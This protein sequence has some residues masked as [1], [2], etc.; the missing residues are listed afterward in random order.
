MVMKKEK[1]IEAILVISTGFL[2]FFLFYEKMWMLYVAFGVG[3]AGIFIKPL[4]SLI[5]RGW[6]KLG[7]LL[8]FVVSNVVLVL[9]FYI[10][11]VPI[12]LLYRLFNKDTLQLRRTNKS[13]WTNRDHEYSADDLKNIW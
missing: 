11:L 9:L 10:F 7:D 8:G 2:L 12:S 1:S 5:A 13:I 4:A 6:Y 3:V